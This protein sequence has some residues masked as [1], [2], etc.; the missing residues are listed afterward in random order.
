MGNIDNI[1]GWPKV[2]DED[3]PR[4]HE[5]WETSDESDELHDINSGEELHFDQSDNVYFPITVF[6]KFHKLGLYPPKWVLDALAER[7]ADHLANPDPNLFSKKFG[8]TGSGSGAT[9]PYD[10]FVWL[11]NR[12]SA[13]MDMMILMSGFDITFTNTARA[14]VEKHEL[15]IEPKSLMNL[16]REIYGDPKPFLKKNRPNLIDDPFFPDPVKG[17]EDYLSEFPRSWVMFITKKSRKRPG[18]RSF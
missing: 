10:E 13:L 7:F 16:F 14:I 1:G 2:I 11:Q 17:R 15:S 9:N 6:Q 8:I 18:R 3:P 4:P 12:R 5:L